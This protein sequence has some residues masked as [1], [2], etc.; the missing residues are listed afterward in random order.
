MRK[1]ALILMSI[2][3]LWATATI[4]YLLFYS[5]IDSGYYKNKGRK[6]FERK[7]IIPAPRGIIFDS[8]NKKLAWNERSYNLYL[9]PYNGFIGRRE[10]VIKALGRI[11]DTISNPPRD[12]IQC[13]KT[14]LS[15]FELVACVEVIKHYPELEIKSEIKRCY[16]NINNISDRETY[17]QVTLRS[18][19][20][21]LIKKYGIFYGI[22]GYEKQFDIN[23]RGKSG[24]FTVLVDKQGRW[25]P[26]TWKETTKSQAGSNIKL[27]YSL[28]QLLT[29]SEK[30]K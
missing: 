9:K 28:E 18:K 6:L 7:G 10:M 29:E 15:P 21:K 11:F 22:S 17:N 3:F 4:V 8:N 14:H 5:V 19:L 30:K 2:F 26:G 24:T 23:L 16:A 25:I 1:R 12:T 13:I 27:K 20:G